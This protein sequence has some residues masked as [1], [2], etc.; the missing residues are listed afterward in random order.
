MRDILNTVSNSRWMALCG[1]RR[2]SSSKRAESHHEVEL[3]AGG[4]GGIRTHGGLAPTAVFK[5]AALNHSATLPGSTINR[6]DDFSERTKQRCH[7][8]LP[9]KAVSFLRIGHREVSTRAAQHAAPPRISERFSVVLNCSH[10]GWQ[11][12]HPGNCL[13]FTALQPY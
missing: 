3:G 1:N 11:G 6:L 10:D 2:W 9:P 8:P 5:T 12:R 4:R 7:R 13:N